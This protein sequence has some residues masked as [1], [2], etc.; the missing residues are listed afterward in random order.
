MLYSTYIAN[1][2]NIPKSIK[3]YLI[4]RILPKG[5]NPADHGIIHLP[6]M[7]PS[8]FLLFRGKEEDYNFF[9]IKFV[10]EMKDRKDFKKVFDKVLG[11]LLSG[12]DVC[13][14]CYEKDNT[15]CHRRLVAERFMQKGIAWKEL[16]TK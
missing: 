1:I 2:Q 10:R 4:V 12:Q 9:K 15:I 8:K 13:I 5:F 3:K 16:P 6:E 14:I 11:E 7:S